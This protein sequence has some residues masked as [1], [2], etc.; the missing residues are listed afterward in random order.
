MGEKAAA[1]AA[2][3]DGRIE[4]DVAQFVRLDTEIKEARRQMKEVRAVMDEHRRRIIEYMVATKTDRLAGINGDT[5]YLECV[6]RTLKK[7]ATSEQMLAAMRSAMASGVVEPAAL[8]AIIQGCG[9]TS[10]E[11]RLSRRTRRISA[12]VAAATFG[13]SRVVAGP[14]KKDEGDRRPPD[15]AGG[16]RRRRHRKKT[17]TSLTVVAADGGAPGSDL[18]NIRAR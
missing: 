16:G 10:T 18:Q 5:Q 8:L 17:T 12:A 9:G 6:S 13:S 15:D 7:R 4:D 14:G 1:A 2:A 11:Y 3:D